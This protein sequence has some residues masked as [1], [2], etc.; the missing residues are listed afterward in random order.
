MGSLEEEKFPDTVAK[1][2]DQI[3][4]DFLAKPDQESFRR[5]AVS[6]IGFPGPYPQKAADHWMDLFAQGAV[7]IPNKITQ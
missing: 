4:P 2:V 7:A 5:I 1:K 3:M 6:A